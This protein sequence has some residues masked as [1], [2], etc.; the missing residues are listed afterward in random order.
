MA[1]TD[2]TLNA[3]QGTYL[4]FWIDARDLTSVKIYIDG[5]RV[6]SGSTFKLNKASGPLY[7]LAHVEKS[8]NATTADV[9]IGRLTVRTMEV[10]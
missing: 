8:S 5:V 9:R 2:T 7:A 10:V 6:L 1:A 4:E 3:T